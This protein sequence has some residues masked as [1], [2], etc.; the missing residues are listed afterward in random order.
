MRAVS[1]TYKQIIASGNTRNYVVTINMTL[2]DNTALT[3]T[4]E[5]IM[6]SS[7]KILTASS[8]SD[9][10]DIGSAI[11]GKCQFTL[12]NYDDSWSQYDFFDAEA[13]VWVGLVGDLDQNENQ[14]YNRMGFFTVDEPQRAGSLISLELLDNMWKFDKDLPTITYPNTIVNI[15]SAICTHC[16]V[17]LGSQSFNGSTYTIASAPEQEMNCR[18]MIQYLAMIGCN[19]CTMNDQGALVIKWYD[20]AS[21]PS[22][23]GTPS[24]NIDNFTQ[25][26]QR[27]VGTENIT[28]T[29]VKFK[30]ND[31]DYL[32]GRE[33]YVLTLEN[34]LVNTSNVS[35]V[36]S[37]I[38]NRLEGFVLRT[39]NV[40]TLPDLAPEVGDCVGIS[41]KNTM[42][43]SYLTNNTF[44]PTLTTVSLGAVTPTRTL[45]QRYSK[46]VQ[47]A[48]EVARQ[49]VDQEI[50]IYDLTAQRM[51]QLAINAMG[52]YTDYDDMPTGGRIYYLSNAP[53]TKNAQTGYCEFPDSA[54]VYKTTGDG[55]FVSPSNSVDPQTGERIWTQ[56]YTPST[57]LLVELLTAL[58]INAEQ[59][60]T[61]QLTVGGSQIGVTKPYIRVLDGSNNLVCTI[62]HRGIIMSMGALESDD[63]SYTS[64][65]FSDDGTR[66]DVTND[67]LRSKYFAFDENGAYI[68]GQVE[69]TSGKI[70]AATIT[71]DAI[72]IIGDVELYSG[73][74]TFK[75]R[76][77]DY[78]FADDFALTLHTTGSCTVTLVK[79]ENGSDTTVGTYS[80]TSAE[81]EE[82]ALLDHTIGT[83]TDDYY[84]VTVSGSSCVV[85]ALDVILAYMGEQG[86]LGTLRGLFRG[87]MESMSGTLGGVRYD[88]HRFD[89]GNGQILYVGSNANKWLKI[90]LTDPDNP[91]VTRHYLNS[92]NQPV[93]E[94]VA[95]GDKQPF[96]DY[97]ILPP[98]TAG[99]DGELTIADSTN[100][101]THKDLWR[102]DATNQQWGQINLGV[103][104]EGVPLK[105]IE[106]S[107][108]DIGEGVPMDAGTITLVYEP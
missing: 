5:D 74:G 82:T 83:D 40:T 94:D 47:T 53:I 13:T 87:H 59:L 52:G 98:S 107:P 64:G 62:D 57:G 89:V 84:Q 100:M 77:T 18:E 108:I 29:G 79:H 80:V 101:G 75:F 66:F 50:G 67:Y 32:I 99:E 88:D 95:W 55:F 71:Q 45:T 106:V 92:N 63:Y 11:I 69:A 33:G 10:F 85:S 28:I 90:D 2:A 56:G 86:F 44:T 7:F 46:A 12:V 1:S 70:G 39:F 6:Q 16:G 17:I 102:Y 19:F 23:G 60:F 15:I 35:A 31:T 3:I 41:Y 51:N 21:Y 20:T 14:I 97:S 34:P 24:A 104:I 96:I 43:Y 25:L 72:K 26:F 49:R 48:V 9:S 65:H 78:Y 58:R 36:L 38:W 30:I 73:S 103:D 105:K 91:K 8:G 22:G 76:P 68:N 42:I 27:N 81:D 54:V 4:E 93:E 61:G 37:L